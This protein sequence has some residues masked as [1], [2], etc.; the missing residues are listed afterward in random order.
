MNM[1]HGCYSYVKDSRKESKLDIVKPNLLP[2]TSNNDSPG[3][4]VTFFLSRG[5]KRFTLWSSEYFASPAESDELWEILEEQRTGWRW[6]EGEIL[7]QHPAPL[8]WSQLQKWHCICVLIFLPAKPLCV[9]ESVK[10]Q[11]IDL[12]KKMIYLKYLFSLLVQGAETSIC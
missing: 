6:A 12:L 9:P 4:E 2:P 11:N 3:P 8:Q 10:Q 1:L 7:L 5:R